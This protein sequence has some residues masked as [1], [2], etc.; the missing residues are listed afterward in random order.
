[1]TRIYRIYGITRMIKRITLLE[2]SNPDNSSIPKIPA[3]NKDLDKNYE[4]A[5]YLNNLKV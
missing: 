4:Q 2:F 5:I 3:K 1:L